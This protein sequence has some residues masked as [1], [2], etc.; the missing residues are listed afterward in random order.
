MHAFLEDEYDE[1]PQLMEWNRIGTSGS[2]WKFKGLEA[3]GPKHTAGATRCTFAFK[4]YMVRGSVAEGCVGSKAFVVC[5]S[6]AAVSAV[7][8]FVS[9]SFNR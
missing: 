6:V 3:V 5:C 7:C 4:A 2:G 1:E 9:V 8:P